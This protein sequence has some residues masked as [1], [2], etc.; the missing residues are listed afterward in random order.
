MDTKSL[1]VIGGMLERLKRRSDHDSVA[2]ANASRGDVT[3]VAGYK[4]M[5]ACLEALSMIDG[6]AGGLGEPL[7]VA[8][9]T[10][11]ALAKHRSTFVEAYGASG[12]DAMR[13]VYAQAV[14][15]LW[16]TTTALCARCVD[17]NQDRSGNRIN[18]VNRDGVKT[19]SESIVVKRLK[20][21]VE[22]TDRYGFN[23]AV[24]L[25]PAVEREASL[26]ED[27]GASAAIAVGLVAAVG[28]LVYI[29]R[30]LAEFFFSVRSSMAKWLEVQASFLELNAKRLDAGSSPRIAQEA[31]VAR[32][33]ALAD[34]IRV[35]ADDAERSARTAIGQQDGALVAG[36]GSSSSGTSGLMI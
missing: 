5:K 24:Q 19:L 22:R 16:F 18:G 35:D 12:S 15:G 11:A 9:A 32:F 21:F 20:D 4:D 25:S 8:K 7:R 34:R 33:R 14:A 23:E 26:R 2:A 27:F 3:K 6:G 28:A 36:A 17:F 10:H 13:L 30:D 1:P 31:H 29:A